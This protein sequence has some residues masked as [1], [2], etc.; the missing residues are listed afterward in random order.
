MYVRHYNRLSHR[1]GT[2]AH[3]EQKVYLCIT[4]REHFGLVTAAEKNYFHIITYY[5]RLCLQCN[6]LYIT[7]DRN[8]FN[9]KI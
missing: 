6:L 9:I 8:T 1:Y 5:Y 2:Q 7:T 4:E 3:H